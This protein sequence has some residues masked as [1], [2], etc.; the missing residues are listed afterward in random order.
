MIFDSRLT[1]GGD[2]FHIVVCKSQWPILM[3]EGRNRGGQLNDCT[4]NQ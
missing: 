3:R 4:S 1:S 2:W